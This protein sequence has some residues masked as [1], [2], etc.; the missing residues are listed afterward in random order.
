MAE[1]GAEPKRRFRHAKVL[2]GAISFESAKKKFAEMVARSP[3]VPSG[4][5]AKLK[6]TA[7]ST[8]LNAHGTCRIAYPENRQDAYEKSFT[9]V[10]SSRPG[11]DSD[12]FK[13]SGNFHGSIALFGGKSSGQNLK[14]T[15][16]TSD[17]AS[18]KISAR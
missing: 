15:A 13:S 2:T 8:S 14:R 7:S 3:T 1:N 12:N 16:S 17:I 6:R 9:A 4:H 5:N 18:H 10:K 11:R